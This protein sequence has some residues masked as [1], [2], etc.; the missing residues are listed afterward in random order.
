MAPQPHQQPPGT[1]Q[2]GHKQWWTGSRQHTTGEFTMTAD[3]PHSADS[4]QE[5]P[6]LVGSRC[7]EH[8]RQPL[9]LRQPPRRGA[10]W[11]FGKG[12]CWRERAVEGN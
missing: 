8:A 2:A 9:H 4:R 3:M 11:P 12:C 1:P 7:Q 5:Q 6:L 10:R